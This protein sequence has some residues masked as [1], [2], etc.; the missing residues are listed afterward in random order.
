MHPVIRVANL[1]NVVS[2]PPKRKTPD[3]NVVMLP[4]RILTPIVVY[5]SCILL[6]LEAWAEC[7]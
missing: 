4:L 3:P 6:F 7:I 1:G 2:Y 5:D